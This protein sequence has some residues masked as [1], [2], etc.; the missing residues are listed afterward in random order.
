[1]QV[2]GFSTAAA[3]RYALTSLS[4]YRQVVDFARPEGAS[5]VIPGGASGIP[6]SPH[7]ADQQ[8]H[9]RTHRRVPMHIRPEDA[10]AA[11]R[12]TLTLVPA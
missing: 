2:A 12:S 6:G 11:A 7:Y 1:V 9:W 5:W 10:R 8:E 4:V 3:T